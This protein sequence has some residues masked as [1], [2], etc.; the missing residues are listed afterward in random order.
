MKKY[1]FKQWI[2]AASIRAIKTIAQ[3]TIAVIGTEMASNGFNIK[4]IISTSLLAGLMSF[5]MSIC[6]LPEINV[7]EKVEENKQITN[8][9]NQIGKVNKEEQNNL[10]NLEKLEETDK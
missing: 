2:I 6:G 5:L 3:S 7:E 1:N 10:K 9:I 4:K 8:Y